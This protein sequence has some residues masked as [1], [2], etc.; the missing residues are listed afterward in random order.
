MKLLRLFAL[1]ALIA[2]AVTARAQDP[3]AVWNTL[4]Q[5]MFD[6]GKSAA[7][8]DLVLVRD[9]VRL[10]LSDGTIQFTQP[11]NGIVFGATFHGNGRLQVEPPNQLEA[12]QLLLFTKQATLDLPFTDATFS[13]TDNTFSEV[14][15]K[16][17]WAGS[18]PAGDDLYASRQKQRED[19]GA[20]IV[21]RLYKAVLS[22]DH[23]RTALF[24]AELKTREK[25][26]VLV[27]ADLMEPEEISVGRWVDVGVV[28]NF[29][30]WMSFPAGG[31]SP[32]EAFADPTARDEYAIRDYHINAAVTGGAE[33]SATSRV[34]LEPRLAGER[35]L[36][37][38]LD[39]NLRVESVKDAQGKPLTY[40]QARETKDRFQSY[41]DYIAVALPEVTQA[42][43]SQTLEFHYAGKRVVRRVG[44]G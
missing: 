30:T 17:P 1:G 22:S 24:V 19:L 10:T 31:R 14:A 25:G 4:W 16:V 27:R 41:G 34:T 42:G 35:V 20:A 11:V 9:R 36:L 5:P 2:P 6:A 13:F 40:F 43:Q 12:Q 37:F 44:N 18:G 7:V 28:R 3:T 15:G 32:R 23:A 39:S 21:P 8:K 38:Y 26:W 29:D 33:L